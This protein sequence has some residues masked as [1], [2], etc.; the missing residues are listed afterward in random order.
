MVGRSLYDSLKIF[1]LGYAATY[2]EVKARFRAN[3]RIYHP[4]QH[5]P[6]RTGM[7]AEEA[8]RHFQLLNNAHEYLRAKL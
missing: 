8:M 6:E 3:A 1:E 2:Q 5:R 7:T 4:D